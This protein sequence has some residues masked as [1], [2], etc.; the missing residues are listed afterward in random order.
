MSTFSPEYVLVRFIRF[1]IKIGNK[2]NKIQTKISFLD[3]SVPSVFEKKI[4]KHLSFDIKA[5]LFPE[6]S[7]NDLS[8]K[9]SKQKILLSTEDISSIIKSLSKLPFILSVTFHKILTN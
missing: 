1:L 8:F 9:A 5:F 3:P 7:L 4:Q 2:I 6:S